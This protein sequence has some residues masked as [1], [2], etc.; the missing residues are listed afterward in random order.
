MQVCYYLQW[1][2]IFWCNKIQ[3]YCFTFGDTRLFFALVTKSS[4]CLTF[5]TCSVDLYNF[6]WVPHELS[7]PLRP[8]VLPRRLTARIGVRGCCARRRRTFISF[9]TW[10]LQ[11][12][13]LNSWSFFMYTSS[14]CLW[15]LQLIGLYSMPLHMALFIVPTGPLLSANPTAPRYLQIGG[16]IFYIFYF[17]FRIL[18]IYR[19]FFSHVSHVHLTNVRYDL[20]YFCAIPLF[21]YPIIA[22]YA[23]PLFI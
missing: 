23:Y 22:D 9:P 15:H 19:S 10:N 14:Y 5:T 8:I 7:S 4:L 12:Q 6:F 16:V 3:F 13:I 18:I 21:F 11:V 2:L 17:F 1:Q 20:N